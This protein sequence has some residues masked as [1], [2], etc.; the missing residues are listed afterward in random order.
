MQWIT[1]RSITARWQDTCIPGRS[2]LR[3]SW[4]CF[5]NW[6]AFS[7]QCLILREALKHRAFRGVLRWAGRLPSGKEVSSAP[8]EL[9]CHKLGRDVSLDSRCS[10][11]ELM[12]FDSIVLTKLSRCGLWGLWIWCNVCPADRSWSSN[13]SKN[14][15]DEPYTNAPFFRWVF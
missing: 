15:F 5:D 2:Q 14:V 1:M 10:D 11:F 6:E 7:G 4:S 13:A 9:D 3:R 12:A 8:T